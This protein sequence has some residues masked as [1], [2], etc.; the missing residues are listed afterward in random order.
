MSIKYR[1]IRAVIALIQRIDPYVLR[2]AVVPEGSH[3][4]LNPKKKVKK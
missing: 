2:E 1:I 3:I 4:H